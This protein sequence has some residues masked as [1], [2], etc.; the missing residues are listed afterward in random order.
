MPLVQNPPQFSER[1]VQFTRLTLGTEPTTDIA[2]KQLYLRVVVDSHQENADIEVIKP[3]RTSASDGEEKQSSSSTSS[4]TRN[5]TAAFTLGLQP[6]AVIT[7]AAMKTNEE[8]VGSERK[9]YNSAITE[10]HIDGNVRWGFSI[11]DVNLQ[12]RGIDMPEDIL[13]T[14]RFEFVGYSDKPAPPPDYMDI[15]ITSYWSMILPS[16]PKNT[17]IH[18]L[19]RFFKSTSNTQTISYSNLF[20]IVALEANLSNLPKHTHYRAKVKVRG[21]VSG[22]PDVKRPAADSVNVSVVVV[23]GRYI[24]LLTC[25]PE[26]DKTNIFRSRHL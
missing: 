14:V 23:D 3:R 1:F 8:T 6:Q 24:A 25:E 15:V 4:Q 7:G 26:S 16:E 12:K 17:W 11:D 20:Q 2:Y 10:H 19:L 5:M 13:P 22:P 21:G 9:Q 18:K